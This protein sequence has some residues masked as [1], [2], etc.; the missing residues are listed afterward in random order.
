M[1][2]EG[3]R[4]SRLTDRTQLKPPDQRCYFIMRAQSSDLR[5]AVQTELLTNTQLECETKPDRRAH[6]TTLQ[7]PNTQRSPNVSIWFGSSKTIF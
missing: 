5:S 2:G 1:M 6:L 7:S 4:P 3:T